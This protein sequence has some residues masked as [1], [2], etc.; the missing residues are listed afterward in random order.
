MPVNN[1]EIARL[2][3]RVADLLEIE[4]ANPFRVR[5]YRNAARTVRGY[6]VSMREL[7][8]HGKDLSELRHIGDDLAQKIQEIV[9]TGDLPILREIESHTPASLGDLLNVPGLGPKRV[10]ALYQQL[11]ICT[12]EDLRR[13]VYSGKIYTVKGFGKAT[14]RS[15]INRLDRSR[16]AQARTRWLDAEVIARPLLSYLKKCKGV[17]KVTMAGSFR[18]C[19]DTVRDLDILVSAKLDTS[20][21]EHLGNYSEIAR[22]ISMGETRS[23]VLL[24]DGMQ[25]DVRVID[26]AS[27]GAALMYL[28]GSKY[29]NIELR[30][31]AHNLGF[32]LNEY[33]LF[34]NAKQLVGETERDVYSTL[35]L[36]YIEPE[37]R[38]NTG[39]IIAAQ[40]KSLP[41]LINEIDI[42]G[43]LHCHTDATDGNA[44][45]KSMVNSA[46]K[47][48]YEYM[49]IN[50]HSQ[51]LTVAHGLDKA[52][53]LQQ[54]KEI[55]QLNKELTDFVILKS[56]EVDILEDGSLDFPD[57]ILKQLDFTVCAIH[58]KFNLSKEKQT[59][60]II[61]A[62]D[63]PYFNILAH[64]TGRLI[65]QRAA[66]DINMQEIM[67]AAKKRGCILELNA[68]PDRLDLNEVD[69]KLAKE[70]GVKVVISSDAHSQ[71]DLH[72]M[73]LGIN[74][75]R[76]GWL[77]ATDVLNTR[78]LTQLKRQFKPI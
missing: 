29:H 12:I 63:N 13:A 31:Y 35:G 72:S 38:E 26:P 46:R 23:T 16:P 30:T 8:E 36:S 78:P 18:R 17:R 50:D 10:K 62:M 15:I 61:R 25:V 14:V 7:L 54:L 20:I 11:D 66:Y 74:Q 57:S 59:E 58:H 3:E 55:D 48:G 9:E 40:S 28:T 21:M 51:R 22:V 47:K 70:L 2:F 4:D 33:G 68:Q 56:I 42:R 24:N 27:Y 34:R 44:S 6:S 77:E 75:A 52:R 71:D 64:P 1:A 53:L 73:R 49:S 19:K 69:C 67:L 41:Q 39:E 76:R 32:K 43:D 65:N 60:R 37:L 5:A 45:L